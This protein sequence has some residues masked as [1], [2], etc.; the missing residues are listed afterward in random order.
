MF[1]KTLII[2][3]GKDFNYYGNVYDSTTE[4]VVSGSAP[5]NSVLGEKCLAERPQER[6]IF[7]ESRERQTQNV[8]LF[9]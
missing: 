8:R 7:T 1:K 9:C 2:W 6:C 4:I 3:K 5:N